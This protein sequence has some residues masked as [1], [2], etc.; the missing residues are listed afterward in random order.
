MLYSLN[1]EE[2]FA[3]LAHAGF[4]R[5]E[6]AATPPHL[7]LDALGE[8]GRRRIREALQ[9]CGLECCS[10]TP[11]F[12]DLNLASPDAEVRVLSVRRVRA[13]M[14]LAAD[15]EASV[16]VIIPARRHPLVP[17]P[18][19]AVRSLFANSLEQLLPLAERLGVVIG[20]ENIAAGVADTGAEL[21]EL[22]DRYGESFGVVYDVANGLAVEDPALG[23]RA[24]A[25]HLS[26]VHVSDS[27]RQR[28]THARVGAGEIDFREVAR[29]LRD[30]DYAGVT[31]Y[32]LLESTDLVADIAVDALKLEGFGW[33]SS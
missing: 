8:G 4:R 2:S 28:W 9:D 23:L 5:I 20:V 15:L 29:A 12:G 17:V 25:R 7:D 24:A 27:T 19:D 22:G 18:Q 16:V 6:L 31:V 30:V 1:V 11:T 21:A 14:E 10:V 33:T 26:L 13:S 3:A 32:E